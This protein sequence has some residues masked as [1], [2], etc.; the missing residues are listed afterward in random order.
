MS[1]WDY[2][3]PPSGHHDPYEGEDT[4]RS[5]EDDGTDLYPITWERDPGEPP[6]SSWDWRDQNLDWPAPP[7][8]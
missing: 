3:R 4:F 6:T 1:P 5:D 2:G 8:C 7:W